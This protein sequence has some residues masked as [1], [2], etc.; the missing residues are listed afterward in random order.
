V[1]GTPIRAT[2]CYIIKNGKTLLLNRKKGI[3]AGKTNAPGGKLRKN[4]T[5]EK[6]AIREVLEET[7]LKVANLKYHGILNF[8]FGQRLKPDWV[9]HVFSTKS[10]DGEIEESDAGKL[11]WCNA[12]KIPYDKMWADDKYWV[13]F[14]LAGKKFQCW[15]YYD[16]N[17]EKL[18]DY[19]IKLED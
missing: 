12:D 8:F 1:N 7:G 16:E 18:F 11:E 10:F 4:E 2:L 3:G 17:I 6:G 15:F 14:L 13:P 5:L 9:V 19:V